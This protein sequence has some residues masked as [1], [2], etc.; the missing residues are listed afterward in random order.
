MIVRFFK[1]GTS[2][3]EPPVKYVLGAKD[4][5]GMPREEK[6]EVLS[7]IPELTID[8]IN[9][10]KRKHKYSS[11]CLAFRPDE[12]PTRLELHEILQKFKSTV[13]PG[14][15]PNSIDCL[16]VMHQ[17]KPDKK[18]G[19]AGFH[20]HFIFPM[21]R[22]DDKHHGHRWN[23]HPPGKETIELMSLFTS[24]TNHEMGWNQVQP[25]P[26]RVNIDSFWRKVE[27][28]SATRKADL[29]KQELEVAVCN[30]KLKNK[31]QLCDFIVNDLG[32]NITRNGADYVSVKFPFSKK[33]I[34][35]KGPLFENN[36]NYERL[37]ASNSQQSRSV[38]LTDLEY[39][40]HKQRF[41]QLL[42]KRGQ[43]LA[44]LPISTNLEIKN[45]DKQH[46]SKQWQ[47]EQKTNGEPRDAGFAPSINR[48]HLKESARG[49][50]AGPLHGHKYQHA[51]TNEFHRRP[52]EKNSG[53]S[54]H[55]VCTIR[56]NC[57][58]HGGGKFS[59]STRQPTQ[60]TEPTQFNSSGTT[61]EQSTGSNTSRSTQQY[62]GDSSKLQPTN[63]QSIL[64]KSVNSAEEINDQLRKLGMALS[65]ATYDEQRAIQEQ[66][67]RLIGDREQ[68]KTPKLKL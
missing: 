27:G 1:S 15:N 24:T 17:D 66:I 21:V 51:D 30:G 12:Q 33:A 65:H 60:R 4:H 67:S 25:N 31:E 58:G 61:S 19:L 57:R 53:I 43:L 52:D 59:S 23:P 38:M 68:L 45:G 44:D 36:T 40:T 50:S 32:L 56:Q 20:V 11:G 63:T 64:F 10:I 3:G 34:R 14:L 2:R 62:A 22:L 42:Q 55:H 7:G 49:I 37:I 47:R 35:L 13:A 8:L 9:G 16:F 6:P 48:I 28:K 41:S 54:G 29:L 46:Q 26:L 18:T 5:Q 39:K